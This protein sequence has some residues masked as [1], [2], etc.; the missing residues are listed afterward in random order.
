MSTPRYSTFD[1]LA[2][3]D[4]LQRLSS[5]TVPLR[6]TKRVEV[7]EEGDT[8]DSR[9]L[10]SSKMMMMMMMM[11]IPALVTLLS[12]P[13]V[14]ARPKVGRRGDHKREKERERDEYIRTIYLHL[15]IDSLGFR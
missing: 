2:I 3:F 1:A 15:D 8:T 6:M 5:L 12:E 4:H 14:I 7:E 11:M 10:L 13:S 9:P